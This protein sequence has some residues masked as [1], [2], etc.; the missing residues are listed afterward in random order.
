MADRF[1]APVP[2][3]QPVVELTGPEAHHLANV[4]RAKPGDEAILFD[5]EGTET[6]AEIVAV[7]KRSVELRPKALR[8]GA[9]E[10]W[11]PIVLGTAVPKGERFRWLVEKATELGV[12]RLVPLETA[13][14][15]VEPG[16][17]KLEKMRQVVIA[18]SKQAGRSRLMEIAP[19][20][21]WE[22]F[23][24]EELARGV[25]IVAHPSGEGLTDGRPGEKSGD[26]A[27]VLA[28]GPEGGF[29]DSEVD[30]ARAAGALLVS[31]GPRI[32]RVETAAIAL[33][34]WAGVQMAG[35]ATT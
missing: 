7:S 12:T 28:V 25:G 31:L 10:S 20:V 9:G 21:R 24:G 4:L 26:T 13:R 17:G 8:P 1:Y 3:D 33:A 2:L 6:V 29:T 5:G 16:F 22:T 34:A 14:S 27:I 18:A 11:R 19:L 32:L 35:T 23:V 30:S 15:V